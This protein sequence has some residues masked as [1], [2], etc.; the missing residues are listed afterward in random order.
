M[1]RLLFL[2]QIS[3]KQPFLFLEGGK[4]MA[5][6]VSVERTYPT[7]PNVICAGQG[8]NIYGKYDT[9]SFLGSLFDP[10]APSSPQEINGQLYLVP[11]YMEAINIAKDEEIKH[12]G[13]SREEFQSSI[14]ATAGISGKY[15]AFSAH[16]T[17]SYASVQNSVSEYMYAHTLYY[18]WIY[19]I[20]L[21]T[22]GAL[23]PY[24]SASFKKAIEEL[25]EK[26]DTPQQ[27]NAFFNFFREYGAYYTRQV[28]IGATLEFYVAVS[29]STTLST[30][31]VRAAM[32]A[33]YKGL[34]SSGSINAAFEKTQ[35]W[36]SYSSNSVIE[37]KVAGGDDATRAQ[38]G[39]IDEKS[40]SQQTV[41]AY[42]A[43]K[44]TKANAPVATNFQL[45]PIAKLCGQ[46]AEVV[47]A[48]WEKIWPTLHPNMYV[49]TTSNAR[50]NHGPI[51]LLSTQSNPI[52][53]TNSKTSNCGCMVAVLNRTTL[54][55]KF[56]KYYCIDPD[57]S[58]ARKT[59][60]AMYSQVAKDL[61]SA[62]YND[63][64]NVLVFV[65]M[66][67]FA[68][69]FP[70]SDCYALLLSAGAGKN[71]QMWQE[72]Q[73]K[74]ADITVNYALV[75]IPTSGVSKGVEA[76]AI[77]AYPLRLNMGAYFYK[78]FTNLPYEVGPDLNPS[79]LNVVIEERP[80]HDA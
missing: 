65:T 74:E 9:S 68:F 2:Q 31:D 26:A 59:Y 14:S 80:H 37:L 72:Q 6:N 17:S 15:G 71:F 51:V 35:V 58:V 5:H 52:T 40:P 41:S 39:A 57:P 46:K 11:D 78:D 25:P 7:L 21:K 63:P 4:T 76:Y 64:N 42:N 38:L 79:A 47:A 44:S 27:L 55:T 29:N 73:Y 1:I 10:Q 50:E 20:Q 45:A 34:F 32:D 49:E 62:G 75:G 30:S 16:F 18:D 12:S 77:S 67:L 66:G 69:A 36:Q 3:V 23:T 48:A 70:T 60:P 24:L 33:H 53:P 43:W 19:Q 61:T 56:A 54:E 22:P 8:F 13:T 28:T